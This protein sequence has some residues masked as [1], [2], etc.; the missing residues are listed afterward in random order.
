MKKMDLKRLITGLV[1]FPIV[2]FIFIMG[3]KYL[4]DVL[5]AGVAIVSMYEYIKCVSNKVKVVKWI[6]YLSV[7]SI[8]LIHV[9]PPELLGKIIPMCLPVL[10]LILFLH[11][12]ISNMKISFEDIAYTLM[13]I[14]YVFCTLVFIP[15]LF[16]TEGAVPGKILV[17]YILFSAW[18]T[19][20]FAYLVGR[21][22]GKHK[23]SKVSPNK[24][25]EGCIGGLV[26]SVIMSLCFTF[27]VNYFGN[28]EISYVAI[29]LICACL[30]AIG[31]I[32]DFSA[33][34]IKR[35]FDVKDFSNLFPGH[36]G[37]LDRIDSVMFIAPFAC[38]LLTM[39]AI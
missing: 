22:F 6:S 2:M 24:S 4:I 8:A 23:F 14:V 27:A 25:I 28:F 37:M 10:I 15:I 7:A 19:D 29:G 1:G 11:V 30:S 18:G 34:S 16:G 35:H 5:M 38:M 26:G 32:G 33:S 3:N 13:G 31:Q 20:I 17:W 39:F 21:N 12:I 9:I 36:G